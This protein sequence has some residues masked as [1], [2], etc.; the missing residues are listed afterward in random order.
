MHVFIFYSR[1]T[2]AFFPFHRVLTYSLLLT[3]TLLVFWIVAILI[4]MQWYLLV[5]ICNSLMTY[6]V[7]HLFTYLFA[8]LVRCL[9][10]SFA[11]F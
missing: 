1:I 5:L 11:Y 4:G 9:F 10:R 3:L 2:I 7:E 8:T 6:D